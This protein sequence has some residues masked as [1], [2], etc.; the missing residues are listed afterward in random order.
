VDKLSLKQR[1]LANRNNPSSLHSFTNAWFLFQSKT[2]LDVII[3]LQ[4][5]NHVYI[6]LIACSVMRLRIDVT[7]IN[8]QILIKSLFYNST[9]A[10]MYDFGQ[11]LNNN[12]HDLKCVLGLI[13]YEI[14][15]SL[16]ERWI[17]YA[18]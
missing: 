6:T 12:S 5:K 13:L 15:L 10:S 14:M 9:L 11:T 3:S 4:C 1:L 16:E 17:I 2:R 18:I 8:M 7:S